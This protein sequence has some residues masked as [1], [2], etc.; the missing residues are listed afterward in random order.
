VLA[1]LQARDAIRPMR[2][3]PEPCCAAVD[4]KVSGCD[5][6]ISP[7][8]LANVARQNQHFVSRAAGEYRDP[9]LQLNLFLR[10]AFTAR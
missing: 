7:A 8:R 2:R 10:A 5:V 3:D 1:S 4:P 6:L 9:L